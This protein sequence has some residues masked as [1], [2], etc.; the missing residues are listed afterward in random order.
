LQ[1]ESIA[2]FPIGKALSIAEESDTKEVTIHIISK[3][4]NSLK[5]MLNDRLSGIEN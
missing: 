4:Y 1:A 5:N 2:W 3:E